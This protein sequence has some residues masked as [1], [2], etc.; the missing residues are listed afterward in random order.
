MDWVLLGEE[1]R[2]GGGSG[3]RVREVRRTDSIEEGE[4]GGLLVRN[5]SMLSGSVGKL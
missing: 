5:D 1:G 3:G 4:G 2:G